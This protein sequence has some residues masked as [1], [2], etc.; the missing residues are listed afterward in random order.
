MSQSSRALR[1]MPARKASPRLIEYLSPPAEVNMG[2]QWFSIAN[3]GH[4]WIR[5][6]FRVLQQLAGA[7]ILAAKEIAEIGCGHGLLQKEIEDFYGR[8]VTGF[9]LNDYALKQ[10][11]SQVSRLCCYDIFR[12]DPD[13]RAKFDLI[14][15]FDVLEHIEEEDPFLKAVLFHLSPQGRLVVNVPAGQWAYS[16]YDRV[17]GHVRRYSKRTLSDVCTRCG[18]R[19]ENWSYWGFP[20]VPVLM[21]RKLRFIGKQDKAEIITAGMDAG[22]APLNRALHLISSCEP[23]PQRMLGSSLMAILKIERSIL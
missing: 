9:D 1:D 2:D 17:V 23:I 10:N 11:V 18:L 5:R 21:I 16:A 15:L 14:F 22:S 7:I 3:A 8:T 20:L 13:F 12:M 19:V 4:F 6:R